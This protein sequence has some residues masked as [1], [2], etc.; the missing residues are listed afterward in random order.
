MI[1][2]MVFIFPEPSIFID[3]RHKFGQLFLD[4]NV[5]LLEPDLRVPFSALNSPKLY[6][7]YFKKTHPI[8][9]TNANCLSCLVDREILAGFSR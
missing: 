3:P 7:S 8:C 6:N 5:E 2:D 4:K 1:E 9:L